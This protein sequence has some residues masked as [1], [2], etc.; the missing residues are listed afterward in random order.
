MAAAAAVVLAACEHTTSPAAGKAEARPTTV[1]VA[2]AL[3]DAPPAKAAREA[4][5]TAAAPEA[6]PEAPPK[7][8]QEAPQSDTV[9]RNRVA[10]L[11]PLSGPHAVLGQAL[12]DAALLA[13]FDAAADGFVLM[14]FDTAAGGRTAATR[15][16]KAGAGLYKYTV[17]CEL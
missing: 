5:E 15:A 2:P 3:R 9:R 4:P 11:L 10:L 17:H 16:V 14:P 6:P 7:T 13:Q 8:L 1:A 12:L